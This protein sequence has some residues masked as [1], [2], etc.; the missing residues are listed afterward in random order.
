MRPK[1]SSK[2]GARLW[3]AP[4][5]RWAGATTCQ[6][7]QQE[8]LAC[9][10]HYP[11]SSAVFETSQDRSSRPSSGRE[12]K[13]T[14]IFH[15]CSRVPDS[16]FFVLLHGRFRGEVLQ[17]GL[18]AWKRSA[19]WSGIGRGEPKK[20]CRSGLLLLGCSAFDNPLAFPFPRV[21][22]RISLSSRTASRMLRRQMPLCS[23]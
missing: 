6:C 14:Q 4:L 18:S 11:P 2:L 8:A 10:A 12:P 23:N 17:S 9:S 16:A 19:L 21:L 13:S 5:R 7:A 1:T 15:E 22:C 3:Q 20:S